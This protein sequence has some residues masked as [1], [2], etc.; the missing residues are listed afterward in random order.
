M[1]PYAGCAAFPYAVTLVYLLVKGLECAVLQRLLRLPGRSFDG[2][3]PYARR[4][5]GVGASVALQ[6]CLQNLS[7][8]FVSV[9]LYTMVGAS[10]PIFQLSWGISPCFRLETYSSRLAGAITL[11]VVGMCAIAWDAA[12]ASR[13]RPSDCDPALGFLILL[14]STALSGFNGV[15]IQAQ[16][17]SLDSDH[18]VVPTPQLHPVVFTAEIAPWAVLTAAVF[19]AVFDLPGLRAW[20]AGVEQSQDSGFSCAVSAPLMDGS[21]SSSSGETGSS[22]VADGDLAKLAMLLA[23]C[24]SGTLV[25]IDVL[26]QRTII[27]NTSALSLSIISCLKELLTVAAGVLVF[28]DEVSST[29]GVGILLMIMGVQLYT[30]QR[31]KQTK[32]TDGPQYV[33]V[34]D[35][36]GTD[37]ADNSVEQ[38]ALLE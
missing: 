10:V 17:Q 35:N 28:G 15:V 37:A 12:D 4:V 36:D 2:W 7:F 34:S 19:V 5:I 23:L 38:Q 3:A 26:L 11:V 25:C 16:L 9:T 32:E 13:A 29:Q 31:W 14:G 6:I 18:A 30:Y 24:G 22:T 8:V 27:Q 20:F 21:G 1:H 33:G